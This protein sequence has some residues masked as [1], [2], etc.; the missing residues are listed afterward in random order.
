MTQ[1]LYLDDAYLFTHTATVADIIQHEG[2]TVFI[3]DQTIFYPKGGGQPYDTG[4]IAGSNGETTIKQVY[5][6]P[7]GI[8]WHVA[9][10]ISGKIS[11]GDAVNLNIDQDRRLLNARMHSAG[12][13]IDMAMNQTN[14]GKD[15]PAEKGCHIPGQCFVTYHGTIENPTE[16]LEQLTPA[17]KNVITKD[18]AIIAEN[19]STE[20]AQARGVTAPEGKSARWVY[21]EGQ[22]DLGCGCGGTHVQST[23]ELAGITIKKISS[24]KGITRV[25]YE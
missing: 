25:S 10:G 13:A 17:W 20:E 23:S 6:S 14:L 8:V 3:L 11:I 18:Q 22:K 9:E 12:H 21:F 7:D 19:L 24:K 1:L 5:L 4:T 2:Q 16:L 15:L